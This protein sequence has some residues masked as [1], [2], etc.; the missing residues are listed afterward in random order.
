MGLR[1]ALKAATGIFSG[2][3]EGAGYAMLSRLSPGGVGAPPELGDWEMLRQFSRLPW[4]RAVTSKIATTFAAVDWELY[5]IQQDGKAQPAKRIQ[6]AASQAERKALLKQAEQAGELVRLDE[7]PLLTALSGL[8]G[9]LTGH[10]L[11][12]LTCLY[13]DLLGEAFWIK[14]RNAAGMPV[15]FWPVPPHWVRLTPTPTKPSYHV[16][17]RGWQGEIPETEILWMADPNPEFPYGRGRGVAQA[18]ADDL[19]ADQYAAKHVKAWFYNGARPE[20]VI[21]ADGLAP[22][23]TQ[24]LEADWVNKSQGFWRAF[25]PYFMSRKVDIHSINQNFSDMQMVPFRQHERDVVMQVFGIPP[26]VLGVLTNSN[27]STIDAAAYLMASGVLVPRLEFFR[28]LWQQRLVPEYDDR[29]ILDYVSP[30]K[31]DDDFKLRVATAAPWS[32]SID[33]WRALQGLPEL[34]GGRG[35]LHMVP[36][37]LMPTEPEHLVSTPPAVPA[38]APPPPAPKGLEFWEQRARLADPKAPPRD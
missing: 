7:H 33:E 29:I 30:V 5:A 3:N 11:R 15:A 28:D 35:K 22:E 24:R 13:V 34:E 6:R 14:E 16:S 25:R 38:V 18:L 12:R 32:R 9:M 2:K 31:E 23:E 8:N 17:F 36:L 10:A 19:E 1:N 37:T 4:L 20:L 21:T 27:R 26:E